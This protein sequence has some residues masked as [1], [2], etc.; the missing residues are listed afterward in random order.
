MSKVVQFQ[1]INY[2]IRVYS[3]T[4]KYQHCGSSLHLLKMYQILLKISAAHR[5]KLNLVITCKIISILEGQLLQLSLW[6][7][8]KTITCALMKVSRIPM[9]DLLIFQINIQI[10]QILFLSKFLTDEKHSFCKPCRTNEAYS[11][12]NGKFSPTDTKWSQ[13][14]IKT[15]KCNLYRVKHN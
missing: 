3:I 13:E 14:E 9:K 10:I 6:V 5:I 4:W 11:L 2:K 12:H 15:F 7:E 8:L 1:T